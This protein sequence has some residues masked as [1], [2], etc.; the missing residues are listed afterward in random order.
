MKK[1][2][3]LLLALTMSMALV[4]CGGGDGSSAAGGSEA[5]G[6]G[7]SAAAGGEDS[8]I[9]I[10]WLQKNQTNNFEVKI[11][12]GGEA[13]L[14]QYKEEGVISE[15]YLFDGAGDAATQVT[16]AQDLINL[17][18]DAAII[19]P[20]ETEASAPA[21]DLLVEAG[22]PVIEVN[23]QTSNI[24]LCTAYVG[25]NDVE[26]G[27]IMGNFILEV[28]G[29][30]GGYAH[31]QGATG[32]SAAMQRTEGVHNV[33]DAASGWKML[34]EQDANWQGDKASTFTSDWINLYGDELNAIICDNDDMAVASKVA[35]IE[36]GRSDIVVI[37]VDAI[38]SALEMVASGEGDATVFQDG[39]GQGAGAV[40]AA[41]A[42]AQGKEVEKYTWIPF[43]LVTSEN[44]SEY[45]EG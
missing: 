38:E 40:E 21:V 29:E 45:Y 34:D 8:G 39:N 4:A 10:G 7:S 15:Y 31:L 36:A 2:V 13:L 26:A 9:V 30:T 44:I 24:D 25:S 35:C 28:C 23:A 42:V 1:I 18:V 27:E 43:V 14:E 5:S 11:N 3:A 12:E 16:Q 41:V 6:S 17:G 32:N 22:I 19:Q 20:A 37:G 33:M